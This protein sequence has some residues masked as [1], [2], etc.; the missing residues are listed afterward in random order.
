M[1]FALPAAL[2]A[3]IGDP[4][5]KLLLHWRWPL[6]DHSRVRTIFQTKAVENCYF[7]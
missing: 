1:G 7:K 2:G 6:N 5:E 3:K 4:K